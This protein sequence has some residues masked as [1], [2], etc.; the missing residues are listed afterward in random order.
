MFGRDLGYGAIYEAAR[1]IDAFRR[2]LIE[3]PEVAA[4]EEAAVIDEFFRRGGAE[5]APTVDDDV[6]YEPSEPAAADA[7]TAFT[8]LHDAAVEDL[9]ELLAD[10]R[11][12][13]ATVVISHL[14]AEQAAQ[15]VAVLPGDL[16]AEV[17]RR[18]ARLD[19]TD[20]GVLREVE[21]ALELERKGMS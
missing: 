4:D 19:E 10:E 16:Q 11:P 3:L 14:P 20:P 9:A 21:A 15:T 18:L 6:T 17:V 13:T 7:T 2:T 1:I 5:P 12:Q 8:F